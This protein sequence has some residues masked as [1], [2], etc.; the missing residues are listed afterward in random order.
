MDIICHCGLLSLLSLKLLY[1]LQHNFYLSLLSPD[2]WPSS[3]SLLQLTDC[4]TNFHIKLR[5][6]FISIFTWEH[7]SAKT[8]YD[9]VI[10][11]SRVGR[12]E[13]ETL[14]TR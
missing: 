13:E 1:S 2:L 6:I 14:E 7:F 8:N 4:L 11:N 5:Q 10:K 3:L 12:E 9:M